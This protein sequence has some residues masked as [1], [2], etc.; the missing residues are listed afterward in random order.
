MSRRLC[1][2]RLCCYVYLKGF[3][4]LG[5]GDQLAICD[6]ETDFIFIITSDNQGSGATRPILYHELYKNIIGKLGEPLPE[7]EKAYKELKE[8]TDNLKYLLL[9]RTEITH[10]SARLMMLSIH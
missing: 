10:L 4:F 6:P 5:M 2:G 3:A 8:Y 9:K 7:D 1:L